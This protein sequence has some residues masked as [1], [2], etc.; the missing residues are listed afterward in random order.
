MIE[1]RRNNLTV[2]YG[3]KCLTN[4]IVPNSTYFTDVQIEKDATILLSAAS[5]PALIENKD[6]ELQLSRERK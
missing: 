1:G 2:K 6:R 3:I 4:Q 5:S